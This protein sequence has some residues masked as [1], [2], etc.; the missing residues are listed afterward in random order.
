LSKLE[1]I[2]ELSEVLLE[3]DNVV[4][5]GGRWL[6]GGIVGGGVEEGPAAVIDPS[7]SP[8]LDME[9]VGRAAF[10]SEFRRPPVTNP[11]ATP[12]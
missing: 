8:E 4:G 6:T 10:G 2:S 3:E 11:V 5:R 7:V 12:T 1:D 9:V